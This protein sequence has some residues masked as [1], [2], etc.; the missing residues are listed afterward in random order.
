V[1]ERAEERRADG[2]GNDGSHHADED[3]ERIVERLRR[4]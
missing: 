1:T 4:R 2:A 3:A